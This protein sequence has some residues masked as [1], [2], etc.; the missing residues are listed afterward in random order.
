MTKSSNID[1]MYQQLD[2]MDDRT[3]KKRTVKRNIGQP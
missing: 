3:G 1:T 2:Q